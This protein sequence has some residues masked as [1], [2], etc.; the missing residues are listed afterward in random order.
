[1]PIVLFS[2]IWISVAA[3]G[4]GVA[5]GLHLID[6]V[7]PLRQHAVFGLAAVTLALFAHTMVMFYF[8]GTGKNVKRFVADWD[9]E[10]RDD[11]RRKLIE[12]RRKIFPSMIFACLVIVGAFILGGAYEAQVVPRWAHMFPAYA[13]FLYHGHVSAKETLFIFRNVSFLQDVN[14]LGRRRQKTEEAQIG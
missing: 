5:S 2:L 4:F 1:M 8:V 3:M 10:T 11:I 13:A 14:D 6:S 12:T 7:N 9:T